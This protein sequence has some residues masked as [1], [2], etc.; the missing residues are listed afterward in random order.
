MDT[1]VAWCIRGAPSECMWCVARAWVSWSVSLSD[2][3]VISDSLDDEHLKDTGNVSNDS[4]VVV[5]SVSSP[6]PEPS[7]SQQR[8][9]SNAS[10]TW[11]RN[12]AEDDQHNSDLEF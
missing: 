2:M 9:W 10:E 8:L 1:R 4:D 7:S 3:I 12:D 11:D 5:L 6:P